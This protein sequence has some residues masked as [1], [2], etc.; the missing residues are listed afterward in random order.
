MIMCDIIT[1]LNKYVIISYTYYNNYINGSYNP[2]FYFYFTSPFI[3]YFF[4][5][6]RF[7]LL[8]HLYILII[9]IVI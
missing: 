7:V 6:C 8:S 5:S 2:M 4:V 3:T 9:Y 1:V